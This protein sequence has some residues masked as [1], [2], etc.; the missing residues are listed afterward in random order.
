MEICTIKMKTREFVLRTATSGANLIESQ[1][2]TVFN[3]QWI[4]PM[5]DILVQSNT[6]NPYAEIITICSLM[7]TNDVSS[8]MVQMMK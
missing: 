8:L 1:S 5:E 7:A 3:L 4:Y 6:P 2:W